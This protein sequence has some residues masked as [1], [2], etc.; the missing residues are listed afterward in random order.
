MTC[1]TRG[2]E[3]RE[4]ALAEMLIAEGRIAWRKNWRDKHFCWHYRDLRKVQG[5]AVPLAVGWIADESG[6]IV[7]KATREYVHLLGEFQDGLGADERVESILEIAR[8]LRQLNGA[9]PRPRGRLQVL[10][11]S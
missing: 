2:M 7:R 8:K 10:E 1:E 9:G 5:F 3:K 4:Q 6:V 11:S